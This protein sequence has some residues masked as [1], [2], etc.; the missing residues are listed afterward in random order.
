MPT[1]AIKARKALHKSKYKQW[2]GQLDANSRQSV[3]HEGGG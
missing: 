3:I 2:R 1:K